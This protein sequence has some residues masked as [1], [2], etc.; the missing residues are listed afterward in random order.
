MRPTASDLRRVEF[1]N[2]IRIE[3]DRTTHLTVVQHDL[4]D[5]LAWTKT[6]APAG[7]S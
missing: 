4:S 2:R 5:D 7:C 6:H 1:G 3:T